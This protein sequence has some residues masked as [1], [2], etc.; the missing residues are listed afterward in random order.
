MMTKRSVGPVE[1]ASCDRGVVNLS[2]MRADHLLWNRLPFMSEKSDRIAKYGN[3]FS[4]MLANHEP[5][6]TTL[7]H[8]RQ[9]TVEVSDD[10]QHVGVRS[11]QTRQQ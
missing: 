4:K 2:A 9:T 3:G 7:P 1:C 8:R 11:P 10:L 5:L 6:R